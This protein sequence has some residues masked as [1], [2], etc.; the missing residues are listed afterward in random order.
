M[1]VPY[2]YVPD[3]TGPGGTDVPS[4]RRCDIAGGEW[5]AGCDVGRDGRMELALVI[6]D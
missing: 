5:S 6:N 1:P 2:S 4:F 3:V